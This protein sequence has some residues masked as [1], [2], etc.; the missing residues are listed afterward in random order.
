MGSQFLQINRKSL[1]EATFIYK[2][3]NNVPVD[4][5]GLVND[6][7][8]RIYDGDTDIYTAS[9]VSGQITPTLAQGRFDLLIPEA[10]VNLF[11]FR[12]AEFQFRLSWTS[13]GWQEIGEGDVILDE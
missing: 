12:R 6:A 1:F 4:L 2:D 3:S 10:A 11:T 8:F 13:K 5:T 7:E 9:V